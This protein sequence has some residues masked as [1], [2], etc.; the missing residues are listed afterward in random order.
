MRVGALAFVVL[1]LGSLVIWERSRPT[2][3]SDSCTAGEQCTRVLFVGDS[4]TF[5]NDLPHMFAALAASGHHHVVVDMVATVGATF[6]DHVASP[7]TAA[8]LARQHWDIVVLQEQSQRPSTEDLRQAHMYPSARRLVSMVR[9]AGA[10]PLFYLAWAHSN[11]WPEAGMPNYQ[12]M[13]SA[14]DEGYLDIANEV[15]AAVAPVGVAWN[16]IENEGAPI[17]LFQPDGVHPTV[18][19]TYLAAAVF[20]ATIFGQ[21]PI[22]LHARAGLAHADAAT[23]QS[24]ASDV[25]LNAPKNWGLSRLS[26]TP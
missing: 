25:V 1:A 7:D 14:I 10:Q 13:Q 23:L 3:T 16:N 9:A 5:V 11:G 22:G 26:P 12:A 17:E 6:D 8:A 21:S 15:N 2:T 20:Y 4:L 24:V 19:G 18:A